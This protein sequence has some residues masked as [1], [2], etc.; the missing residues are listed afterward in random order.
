MTL[1]SVQAG[2]HHFIGEFNLLES[3]MGEERTIRGENTDPIRP[4]TVACVSSQAGEAEGSLSLRSAWTW[5]QDLKQIITNVQ[6]EVDRS[7]LIVALL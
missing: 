4:G 6:T 7:A 2:Y 5:E 3:I 1:F